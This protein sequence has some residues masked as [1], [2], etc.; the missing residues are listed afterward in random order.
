MKKNQRG[1]VQLSRL[2]WRRLQASRAQT[3]G[4]AGA[5]ASSFPLPLLPHLFQDY[6]RAT[7]R[8]SQ[9]QFGTRQDASQDVCS[10]RAGQRQN[11]GT[12]QSGQAGRVRCNGRRDA[13]L[14]RCKGSKTQ[15]K[16]FLKLFK[17]FLKLDTF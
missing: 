13:N 9:A 6:R 14:A 11:S 4:A 16:L 1:S 7:R 15:C 12:G 5:S 17:T 8:V 2:G 10:V 3:R